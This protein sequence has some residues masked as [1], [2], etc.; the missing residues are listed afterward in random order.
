MDVL[1]TLLVF[2]LIVVGTWAYLMSVA[3]QRAERR[4]N[5]LVIAAETLVYTLDEIN[6]SVEGWQATKLGFDKRRV[7]HAINEAIEPGEWL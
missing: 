5:R 3:T 4:R 6:P 1:D 7:I 2:G